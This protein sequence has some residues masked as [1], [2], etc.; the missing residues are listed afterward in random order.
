MKNAELK[1]YTLACGDILPYYSVPALEALPMVHH[2]IATRG[3]GVSEGIFRSMNLSFSRGDK[4]EAVRENFRRISEV[5]GIPEDHF[6]FTDQTHTVNVRTVTEED[7]GKGLTRARDYTDTD[8]LITDVPG[9][10]LGAFFAD[11]VPIL[12]A[13]PV[14]RAIGISHSGWRGTAGRMGEVTIL[15]MISEFGCDPK[16]IICAVGPSICEKC[17]EIG[18]D[19]AEQFRETFAGDVRGILRETG[20]G[21]YHL[22]LW[23]ANRRILIEAGVLPDHVTVMGVCTCCHPEELFSHRASHGRRGNLGAFI[24]LREP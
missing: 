22:D 9:L 7:A 1:T 10:A 8:G 13:D 11:C 3:G 16:D 18:E 4:E 14:R 5:L 23:E 15:R 21:K 12:F 19:V 17:Y 20:G 2:V 24:A 6:V